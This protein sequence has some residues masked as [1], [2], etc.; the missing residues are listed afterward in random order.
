MTNNEVAELYSVALSM[1]KSCLR[2][3]LA[4]G[5]YGVHIGGAL[6]AIEIVAALYFQVMQYGGESP[7]PI[8]HLIFSKGHGVLAQYAALVEL[9]V[10]TPNELDTFK[11]NGSRLTAHPAVNSELGIDFATGSLGQGLSLGIGQALGIKRHKGCERVYV[12]MGDGECDEGS[13]WE[14]ALFA[15]QMSLDNITVII[16][17]NR[18]QFDALTTEVISLGSLRD[19]WAAFGWEAF[20][21]DGHNVQE[22]VDV[23]QRQQMK[24]RAIVAHTIKGK[25][26]DFME[27]NPEWHNSIL[28]RKL[29]EQ[30][31]EE[32][33]E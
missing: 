22:L 6:S 3:G 21:V 28:T 33:G 32:L 15:P 10:V 19:K 26:I 31:M 2:M 27:N 12:I 29:Y 5:G 30:A 14:A 8:D 4:A 20:D 7:L 25:G 13:V 11:R 9:G 17:E 18:L 23:L 1:R 16:D 24:P